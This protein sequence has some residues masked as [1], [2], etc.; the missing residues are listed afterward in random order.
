MDGESEA[1]RRPEDMPES[2][3]P[4]FVDFLKGMLALDPDERRSAAEM[5][6]HD[7]LK[8]GSKQE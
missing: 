3:V 4:I 1:L 7:W 8:V 5:L 6:E 2:E